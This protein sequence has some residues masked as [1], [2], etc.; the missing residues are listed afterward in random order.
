[1]LSQLTIGSA[2]V[3]VTVLVHGVS[4]DIILTALRAIGMETLI[5]WRLLSLSLLVLAVFS[6]HLIEI[7]I[8][9]VFYFF[10][11]EIP[12]FKTALYFSTSSFTTVGYGDLTL[13]EEW[14]LL[15]SMESANGMI[16]FGWS[17]AFIF[18]VIHR[19]YEQL[20]QPR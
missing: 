4:L 1:M 13:S 10:I 5:R 11:E 19:I 16:L 12:T 2:L 20:Y 3:V 18:T 14:R 17:T 8:W 9:A 6:A 7:W 15:G